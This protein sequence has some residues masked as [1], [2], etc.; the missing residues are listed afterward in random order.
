MQKNTEFMIQIKTLKIYTN[1]IFENWRFAILFSVCSIIITSIIA[2]APEKLVLS[3]RDITIAV[4]K[5]LANLLGID[6]RSSGD[7]LYINNFAMRIIT[8]CTAIHY[9]V[10]LSTAV[11]LY[12][13]HSLIYR[14][15]G[16]LTFI[17]IIILINAIR[18]VIT[19]VVGS[20]SFAL[21]VIIHDYLWVVAFAVIVLLLWTAWVEKSFLF[22]I[23]SIVKLRSTLMVC[24]FSFVLIYLLQQ[25]IGISITTISSLIISLLPGTV[26][27]LIFWDAGKIC[28]INPNG[29]Y[30]GTFI[31][32]MLIASLYLGF[33]IPLA[34]QKTCSLLVIIIGFI[35]FLVTNSACIALT[36]YVALNFGHDSAVLSLW[37]GHSILLIFPLCA[38]WGIQAQCSETY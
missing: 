8:Q 12:S 31:T 36:G 2:F 11:F 13:R 26:N 30:Q 24:S 9:I 6:A 22:S 18:L 7:I 34:I 33:T 27:S 10:I 1:S 20:Y 5:A 3:T 37:V 21:F 23:K 17:P 25:Y 38:R 32:D 19:G 4:S 29:S 28:F 35:I 16:F 15:Q 14:L